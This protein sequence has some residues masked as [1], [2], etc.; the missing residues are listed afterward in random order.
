MKK[1]VLYGVL[2][3]LVT[4]I[5]CN[6]SELDIKNEGAYPFETYLAS[7]AALNQATTATYST[8]LHQGLWAR[9]YYFMFDLMGGD[10]KPNQP[11][12]GDLLALGQFNFGSDQAQIAQFWASLYRMI[13]RA[14]IVI[15]RTTA[16]TAVTS[17]EIINKKQYIAEAKFLKAYANFNLV[18]CF[19]A[20]PLKKDYA[21]SIASNY[22][23]RNSVEEVWKAIED[24]LKDAQIDL[25]V[26]YDAANL[27]RVTKGA[28]TALL[29]K[30]YLYQK[31]WQPAQ[32]EF[33]KLTLPPYSYTLESN[34]LNVFNENN[35]SSTENIF[36]V[37][38]KKWT[39][40]GEGNQYYVFGG[41]EAW[42]GKHTHSG[43]AQ[44][45]GFNDWNNVKLSNAAVNAFTYPNPSGTGTYT[46][47]R[48]K[49]TF[50]G[51]VAS[52]GQ[53][54]Y[55]QSCPGGVVA[56]KFVDPVKPEKGGFSPLKYQLYDKIGTYGG[57]QSGINS[58]VIR[59]A[60]VLLMLAETYI[61]QGNVG[62][63]PLALINQVRA[64]S[65]AVSYTSLGTPTEAVTILMR[66]R[67][68]E[69]C[70]EQSRYFDLV[71][72]GIF[73]QTMNA[74]FQTEFGKQP[75]ED[76]HLLFPI[77]AR[78]KDVNPN[79]SVQNGWN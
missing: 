55:C 60:D 58:Q 34:Y 40:W 65:G 31:K 39:S 29:G 5:S 18:N 48:A 46:D 35:Q 52:G 36:Q 32:A 74:Q 41:Q 43:I 63:N 12:L 59:Y 69:L 67:Q 66:E 21:S 77:P 53:T 6:K 20:I 70:G 38:H 54:E 8:L 57:P 23:S 45:Y 61:Q 30:A 4:S 17:N 49:F 62:S 16:W 27:G 64:R 68:I 25:P 76:K 14:N 13:L 72:W 2:T 26:S 24:D 9:E 22:P 73:K 51:D 47:P 71:R 44:E 78:E 79:I 7:D 75:I 11:L 10:M 3:V 28:A 50:Y 1:L 42:G 37:M 19:G 15:D 33:T 56:Y